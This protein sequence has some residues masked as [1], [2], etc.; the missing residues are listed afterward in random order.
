[1]LELN[2]DTVNSFLTAM[3]GCNEWGII[4]I[5]D[6]IVKY[7][8]NNQK[9]TE[10]IMERVAPRL[11][12]TNAGVVLSTAK[13]LMKFMDYLTNPDLIRKMSRKLT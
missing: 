13:V 4:N 9:D 10:L 6:V 1:M 12:H 3:D 7:V 11:S 2:T 8:T 5:L